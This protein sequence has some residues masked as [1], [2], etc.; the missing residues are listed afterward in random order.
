V[1]TVIMKMEFKL[2]NGQELGKMEIKLV[3]R[4]L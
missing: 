3:I 2:E 1:I 4:V